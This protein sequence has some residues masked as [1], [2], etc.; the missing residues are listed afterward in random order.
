MTESTRSGPAAHEAG[1]YLD[2]SDTSR[3]RY[4]TGSEWLTQNELLR[5]D[6]GV[7]SR[8]TEAPNRPRVTSEPLPWTE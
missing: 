4:W 8:P 1:W 2:P 6:P 3:H 7:D 5:E